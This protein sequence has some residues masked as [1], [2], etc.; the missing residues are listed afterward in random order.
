MP[1]D[2]ILYLPLSPLLHPHLTPGFL[3]VAAVAALCARLREG[4]NSAGNNVAG[5]TWLES[6]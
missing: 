2:F 1:G 6:D 3:T 5:C 4:E